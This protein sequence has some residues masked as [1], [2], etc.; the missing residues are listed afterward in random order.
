MIYFSR[1]G[2]SI[3]STS[4]SMDSIMT[5]HPFSSGTFK[6]SLRLGFLSVRMQLFASSSGS[7]D[8]IHAPACPYGSIMSGYLDD[9]VTMIPF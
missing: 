2:S 5:G 8:L 4:F 3:G 1:I 9:L 6:A 7:L